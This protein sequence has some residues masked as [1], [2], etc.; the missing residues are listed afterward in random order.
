[1][2]QLQESGTSHHVPSPARKWADSD[3]CRPSAA[4]VGDP[5]AEVPLAQVATRDGADDAVGLIRITGRWNPSS[6]A[7]IHELDGGQ[8]RA[9]L[10]AIREWMVLDEVPA[11]DGGLVAKSG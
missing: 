4:T 7:A 6:A 2:L 3:R 9:A 11:Q 1:M 8:E 5:V 10:I